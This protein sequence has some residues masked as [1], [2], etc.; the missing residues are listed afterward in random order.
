MEA[1]VR[2]QNFNFPVW[3]TRFYAEVKLAELIYQCV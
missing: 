1:L 2:S 3:K